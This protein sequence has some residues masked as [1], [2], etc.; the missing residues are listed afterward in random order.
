MSLM[1]IAKS[2]RLVPRD[3]RMLRELT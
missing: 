2:S 3:L 1:S